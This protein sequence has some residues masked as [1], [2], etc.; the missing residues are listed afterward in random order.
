MTSSPICFSLAALEGCGSFPFS[1][2][3]ARLCI[4]FNTYHKVVVESQVEPFPF[5]V[6]QRG[7]ELLSLYPCVLLA[8]SFV[9]P[10]RTCGNDQSPREFCIQVSLQDL[11][12]IKNKIG[13]IFTS[14]VSLTPRLL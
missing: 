4:T 14:K 5:P 12:L 9:L 2:L 10:P 6:Y 7:C 11:H 3:S 1:S 13:G 8:P